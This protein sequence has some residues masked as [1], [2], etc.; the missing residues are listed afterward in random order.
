[1]KKVIIS[2]MLVAS[3]IAFMACGG[4][5][6]NSSTTNTDTT[7]V[8]ATVDGGQAAANEGTACCAQGEGSEC[9]SASCAQKDSCQ[10][11]CGAN[12]PKAE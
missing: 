8:E 11:E 12:C 6:S 2:A 3:A 10:K 1:M 9:D 5:A 7:T 4:N